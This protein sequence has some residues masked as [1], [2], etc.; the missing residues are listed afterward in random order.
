MA[1]APRSRKLAALLALAGVLVLTTLGIAGANESP[2]DLL[3]RGREADSA[4]SYVVA[5]SLYTAACETLEADTAADPA[6]LSDAYELLP[7]VQI[8]LCHF[9]AAESTLERGL[10]L[11]T[12]RSGG[13]SPAAAA[14]LNGLGQIQF[15]L[16]HYGRAERLCRKA[17]SMAERTGGSD[18]PEVAAACRTLAFVCRAQSRFED[19]KDF[20]QRAVEI[21][22]KHPELP[23]EDLALAYVALAFNERGHGGY[24]VAQADFLQA[25]AIAQR[26]YQDNHP[27]CALIYHHAAGLAVNLLNGDE[28]LLNANRALEII[29]RVLGPDH[30]QAGYAHWYRSRAYVYLGRFDD[31]INES[32]LAAQIMRKHLGATHPDLAYAIGVRGQCHRLMNRFDEAM[33]DSWEASG[34]AIGNFQENTLHLDESSAALATLTTFESYS[35]FAGLYFDAPHVSPEQS[36]QLAELVVLCKGMTSDIV[37]WRSHLRQTSQDPRI[38]ALSA[39]LGEVRAKRSALYFHDPR[40]LDRSIRDQLDQLKVVETDLLSELAQLG[41]ELPE[42]GFGRS[43]TIEQVCEKIPEGACVVDFYQYRYVYPVIPPAAYQEEGRYAVVV[44]DRDGVR[45]HRNLGGWGAPSD[46]IKVLQSLFGIRAQASDWSPE[47]RERFTK[48]SAYLY[49]E[50]WQPIADEIG[51]GE[52]VFLCPDHRIGDLAFGALLDSNGGFLTESHTFHYLESSRDLLRIDQPAQRG[53]GL[54][55]L[56]DPDFDAA[57][58]TRLASLNDYQDE[59]IPEQ[60]QE[61]ALR[62]IRPTC[63]QLDSLNLGRLPNTRVEI[64]RIEADWESDQREPAHAFTGPAANEEA[65]KHL[66][67]GCRVAHIA[68]HGYYVSK[69]CR[70]PMPLGLWEDERQAQLYSGL[71]LAGANLNGRDADALG[72]ED[73]ILT[74]DEVSTLDFRGVDLVVLSACESALGESHPGQGVVGIAHAFQTAGARQVVSALWPVSD[75]VSARVMPRIYSAEKKPICEKLR[76]FAIEMIEADRKAGRQPDPFYWA[77]YITTGDWRAW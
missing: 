8:R 7:K 50:F 11:A 19:G 31:A 65:V 34:N 26:A 58:A 54:F 63:E 16:G 52:V 10:V 21:S 40:I 71:L 23:A 48:L 18:D 70:G 59:R 36:R 30:L 24:G 2:G 3:R 77:P 33:A 64:G 73:G 67:P 37:Y 43:V 42:I 60:P 66:M 41:C 55:A 45:R 44:L 72:A 9:A 56:A 32:D 69:E 46:S 20:A 1:T 22:R 49:N 5:E 35:G 17:L 27:V 14:C 62:N 76:D 68:T 47:G 28:G 25:H 29:E 38:A 75:A 13:E 61:F 74:G 4:V 6:L 12:T 39:R 51:Q 53:Q 57:P 15:I